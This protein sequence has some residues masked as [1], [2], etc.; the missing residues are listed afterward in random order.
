MKLNHYPTIF[1]LVARL[2]LVGTFVFAALPKI[3][4]PIEFGAA[5]HGFQV[6]DGALVN[7]TALTLPWLELIISIG[8]LMP[9]IRRASGTLIGLLLVVFITLHAS[10]WQRGLDISC[11]CFGT[12]AEPT[13][14]YRLLILRNVVL[15]ALT[16]WIVRQDFRSQRHASIVA[17]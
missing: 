13:A 17:P 6:I 8:L 9:M 1:T 11:G 4:D 15:L 12:G 5:I 10:A 14:D 7:W 2:V 16:I 3:K